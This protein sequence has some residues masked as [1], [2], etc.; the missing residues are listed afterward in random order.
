MMM[1]MMSIIME[2]TITYRGRV[3][4]K[5]DIELIRRIISANPS[6]SR[7]FISQ[8]LCRAWNWR[9]A[10]GALKDMVC[11]SLLLLVE[12]KG[13]IKLPPPKRKLANPLANRKPPGRVALDQVPIHGPIGALFPIELKQ[14]RRS[15]LEKLCNSLISQHHYLGYTQPVG[16]HLK[17][18]A[19]SHAVPIA[20]LLWS[21]AP[22]YIGARDRFIGWDIATRKNNLHLIAYQSR[23]LILPW[24]RVS[25]LASHLL[26]LNR[27]CISADWQRLYAHPI[28]LIETFVDQE[29]F[30]GTCYKADNWYRAGETTGRGKLS[31]SR[32]A[33]LPKKAVYLYPLR[34]D[35]RRQLCQGPSPC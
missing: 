33:I 19:F 34:K 23:F 35:F 14:V 5:S 18:M 3:I 30:S 24:V 2:A 9:Q 26:A 10:N 13:L 6:A 4:D 25:H 15:P 27:R 31:K 28:H 7:R 17:Y 20:C 29:R 1:Y 21:S 12:S 16:E 8:E 32:K 11:R 22:W